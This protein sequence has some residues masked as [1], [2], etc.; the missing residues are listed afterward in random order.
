MVFTALG[1]DQAV[2]HLVNAAAEG[3]VLAVVVV[4]THVGLGVGWGL[5]GFVD[6][7]CFPVV[8]GN[9]VGRVYGCVADTARGFVTGTVCWG[10]NGS[11]GDADFLTVVGLD[12]RTVF[13][14]SS[15]D[16]AGVVAVSPVDVDKGFR[17]GSVRVRSVLFS[18]GTGTAVLLLFTSDADL[19][20]AVATWLSLV[21]R[22]LTLPSGLVGEF[23]L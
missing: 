3:V 5:N 16:G 7:S 20:L 19:F 18:T 1:V 23:D 4:V 22:V 15:V 14:L 17:V 6:D 21:R 11:A 2:G 13:A 8:N 12:A 10:V 9:V